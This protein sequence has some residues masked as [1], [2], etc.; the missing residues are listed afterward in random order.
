MLLQP[1]NRARE[2]IV[3]RV[4]LGSTL[5]DRV[6]NT[7]DDLQEARRSEG[8][9]KEFNFELLRRLF[10]TEEYAAEYR[11]SEIRHPLIMSTEDGRSANT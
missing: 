7:S 3:S 1:R 2:A 10:T 4:D 11:R 9:W 6:I 8:K 5:R